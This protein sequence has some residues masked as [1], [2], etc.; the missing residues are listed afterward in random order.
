MWRTRGGE[1]STASRSSATKPAVGPDEWMNRRSSPRTLTISVWL[2]GCEGSTFSDRAVDALFVQGLGGE[3]AEDVA[4]RPGRRS[5]PGPPAG[6]DPT[7]VLAAPP[8]MFRTR[9]STAINSP[10]R[11]R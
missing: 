6:R 5:P 4:R 7:A 9:S 8:P 10:G 3:P 1:A 2:V 11:G